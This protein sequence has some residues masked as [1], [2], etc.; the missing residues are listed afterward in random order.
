MFKIANLTDT[1]KRI[2]LIALDSANSNTEDSVGAIAKDAKDVLI[3]LSPMAEEQPS[4]ITA[5][6]D[7]FMQTM[8]VTGQSGLLVETSD[9]DGVIIGS[10][11]IGSDGSVTYPI[12]EDNHDR[13]VPIYTKAIDGNVVEHNLTVSFYAEMEEAKLDVGRFNPWA[14]FTKE[15]LQRDGQ[16]N[17]AWNNVQF[18][19][20]ATGRVYVQWNWDELESIKI[21]TLEEIRE[22]FTV[23]YGADFYPDD[24]FYSKEDSITAPT[25]K[26]RFDVDT[27]I[28]LGLA[29]TD[30]I[31]KFYDDGSDTKTIGYRFGLDF[32]GNYPLRKVPTYLP[33]SVKN[34]DFMFASSGLQ[35]FENEAG[36]ANLNLWD[37]GHIVT[38]NSTFAETDDPVIPISNWRPVN[39]TSMARFMSA[40]ACTGLGVSGI[41]EWK[42]PLLTNINE[43]FIQRYTGSK[44]YSDLSQWCIPLITEEPE[45]WHSGQMIPPAWG[46]CP[47]KPEDD[48]IPS[49]EFYFT[50]TTGNLS[51]RGSVGDVI[52]LSDGTIY[53]VLGDGNYSADN[54]PAG[55]HKVKLVSERRDGYV[56]IEGEA[57]VELHNFPTLSVVNVMDFSP[58]TSS[59]NLVKVP[60]VLPSNITRLGWMFFRAT[61]FNQ[62]ISMWDTSNITTMASMFESASSF[63]QDIS[64]WNTSNVTNMAEMFC[65]AELF[66]Q[67]IG[68]W[69][70]SNVTSMYSMFNTAYAFNRPI[71]NW[72]VSNVTDMTWMFMNA[73]SFN[74]DLSQ[75]CVSNITQEPSHFSFN[76]PLTNQHKP[77]WGTCP[78]SENIPDSDF[79][80]VTYIKTDTSSP[81]WM[82]VGYDPENAVDGELHIDWGDGTKEVLNISDYEEDE[83]YFYLE[84]EYT[85]NGEYLVKVYSTTKAS[86]VGFGEITKVTDWGSPANLQ[87]YFSSNN[88]IE[89][90]S[91]LHPAL[92]SLQSMFSDCRMFNQDISM[93]DTSNV[94]NMNNMFSYATSFNQDISSWDTSKVT[95]MGYMFFN[96]NAFNSDLSNW[97]VS[98]VTDMSDMFNKAS[99]FNSDISNWNVSNVTNMS[100]MFSNA[101]AFNQDLSKWCVSKIP[102]KPSSFDNSATAWTLPRPVWGTCPVV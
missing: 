26:V 28:I 49:N 21:Y 9:G 32:G 61:S 52:E 90:P 29:C 34:L 47:V 45:L 92:T 65:A 88:L 100:S 81:M 89:M 12:N 99:L 71:G 22:M 57:L 18:D 76:S 36:A 27:P 15:I 74:Q 35:M 62:D 80:K 73:T 93:W 59:P 2:R 98:S 41:S 56:G 19:E 25:L 40:S 95:N 39:L 4:D 77:V 86:Y 46:T 101:L 13:S 38:M 84:H 82:N 53:T 75:W 43:A 6:Y 66:N 24:E 70:V 55:K 10:G 48:E 44:Y 3:C 102:T 91:T 72:D 94:T 8:T 51:Y 87:P 17:N 16:S 67:P 1:N 20:Q 85:V 23:R 96:A 50:T 31:H 63:N 97:D 54:V 11:V 37:V 60:T 14:M 58:N 7:N 33:K 64:G 69:D 5:S 79:T 30:T 83:Y 68:S 42:T 78:S